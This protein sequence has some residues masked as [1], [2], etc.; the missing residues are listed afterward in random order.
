MTFSQRIRFLHQPWYC[1]NQKQPSA[2]L[3]KA[4]LYLQPALIR[5]LLCSSITQNASHILVAPHLLGSPP[6][7]GQAGFLPGPLAIYLW[8]LSASHTCKCN[9]DLPWALI[10]SSFNPHPPSLREGFSKWG[11]ERGDADTSL[12]THILSLI[13]LCY[14][15]S[16]Q[17][18]LVWLNSESVVRY[19]E[20]GKAML[21]CRSRCDTLDMG[22]V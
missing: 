21:G 13:F 7:A 5:F 11:R 10:P 20:P 18:L 1:P 3:M 8:S 19:W 15:C 4:A 14:I 12:P 22:E 17:T 2:F 9:I 16:L 6:C